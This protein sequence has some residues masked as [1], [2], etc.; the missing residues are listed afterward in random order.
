VPVYYQK[1]MPAGRLQGLTLMLNS[2]GLLRVA[3]QER[4]AFRGQVSLTTNDGHVRLLWV[5]VAPDAVYEVQQSATA[6]FEAPI[7][8][9]VGPDLATFVS[10]LNDGIYYYRLQIG[11]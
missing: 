3:S 9:Y 1:T 7:T 4:H 2:T 10:G 6:G 5:S 11:R 8:I